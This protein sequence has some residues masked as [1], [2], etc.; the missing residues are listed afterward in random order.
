MKRFAIT[1]TMLSLLCSCTHKSINSINSQNVF[2][3]DEIKILLPIKIK[4][5]DEGYQEIG[6]LSDGGSVRF[7]TADQSG[8]EFTF[9]IDHSFRI[10]NGK[11]VGHEPN[12]I[13]LETQSGTRIKIKDQEMFKR[14]ALDELKDCLLY[15]SDAADD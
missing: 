6:I 7:K 15:T 14:R 12:I 5:D 10:E 4:I 2:V 9:F 8:A 3:Q 1:F 11:K 13:Y